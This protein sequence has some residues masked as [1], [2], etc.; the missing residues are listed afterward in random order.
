[1]A[2]SVAMS[3]LVESE[4]SGGLAKVRGCDG[5]R[6]RSSSA[7]ARWDRRAVRRSRTL[8]SQTAS[9]R[10]LDARYEPWAMRSSGRCYDRLVE[11]RDGDR[12]RRQVAQ[13]IIII[14]ARP[15]GYRPPV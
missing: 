9:N 12:T 11:G 6:R 14:A 13:V 7:G 5:R 1:M 10:I 2:N 3:K 4:R 8:R 15:A